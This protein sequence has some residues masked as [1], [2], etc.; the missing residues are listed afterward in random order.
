MI[1]NAK[2]SEGVSKEDRLKIELD[3]VGSRDGIVA[4]LQST[5]E[6]MKTARGKKFRMVLI[7][8]ERETKK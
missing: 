1:A 6:T 8:R 7:I 4:L 3:S 5:M 2:G